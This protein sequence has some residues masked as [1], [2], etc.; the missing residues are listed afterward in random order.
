MRTDFLL[1]VFYTKRRKNKNNTENFLNQIHKDL[2]QEVLPQ[3]E[4]R[5]REKKT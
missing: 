4:K 3:K 1:W 2:P 5:L